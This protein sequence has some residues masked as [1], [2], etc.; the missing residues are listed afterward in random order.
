MARQGWNLPRTLPMVRAKT[1]KQGPG[2]DFY[3]TVFELIDTRS[4]T[5]MWYWI[6]LA[7]FWSMVSHFVLGVPFDLVQRAVRADEAESWKDLET[8]TQINA[9]RLYVIGKNVGIGV[10]AGAA[11]V[12]TVLFILGFVYW[13]EFCQ[14]LFFLLFPF[15]VVSLISQRTARIVIERGPVRMELARH[16]RRQRLITQIIGMISIFITAFW[17]VFKAMETGVL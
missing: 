9:R 16:L 12:L 5:S 14:A 11:F 2:L 13:V 17:G 4:F 1:R 15:T 7:I 10:A 6:I 3:L 8:L